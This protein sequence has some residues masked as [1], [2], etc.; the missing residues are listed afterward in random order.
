[1]SDSLKIA[2]LALG[3]AAGVAAAVAGGAFDATP[4]PPSLLR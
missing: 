4:W 3:L 2:M 1:M